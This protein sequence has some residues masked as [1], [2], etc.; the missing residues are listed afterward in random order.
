MCQISVHSDSEALRSTSSLTT[1]QADLFS[2]T[3]RR[4][5]QLFLPAIGLLSHVEAYR[6]HFSRKT[7]TDMV[8]KLGGDSRTAWLSIRN[9][10]YI[11][12]DYLSGHDEKLTVWYTI[13]RK[14]PL[15]SG[16]YLVLGS[17]S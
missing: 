3:L 5:H 12:C 14:L 4:L 6:S 15:P 8:T 13:S 9:G 17:F 11:N 16:T 10:L 2:S 7:E 1:M